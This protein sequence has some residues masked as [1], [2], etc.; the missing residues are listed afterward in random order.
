[1]KFATG[2]VAVV[3]GGSVGLCS[4]AAQ[5]RDEV[6]ASPGM[7]VRVPGVVRAPAPRPGRKTATTVVKKPLPAA[8]A[9]L[10]INSPVFRRFWHLEEPA[11]SQAGRNYYQFQ[12]QNVKYPATSLRAGVGGSVAALLTVL[13][14]GKVGAVRITR[15]LLDATASIDGATPAAEAALD[16]EVIRVVSQMQFEPAAISADTVTVIQRFVFE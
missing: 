1:M 2:V 11:R 16:A 15:R 9:F 14:N 3:L 5:Q 12:R 4:V 6:Y 10:P 13:P 8:P 7:A